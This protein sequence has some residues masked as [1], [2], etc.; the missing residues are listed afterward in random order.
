[1]EK[2]IFGLASPPTREV[3][4]P[5]RKVAVSTTVAET[6]LSINDIVNVVDPNFSKHKVYNTQLCVES[7]LVSPITK[8]VLV[9]VGRAG[10]T[11]PGKCFR[12][13]TER[14]F[15]NDL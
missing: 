1:M 6:S 14:S 12:L 8:K 13:Y 2:N 11:Q 10:C 5:G 15:Q 9:R 7:L 4:H 3:S